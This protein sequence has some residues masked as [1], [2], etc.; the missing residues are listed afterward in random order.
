MSTLSPRTIAN[1]RNAKRSTGPKTARG[2]TRS[3]A[4]ALRH[5]LAASVRAD[6]HLD[7]Q[8]EALAKI[9]AGGEAGPARLDLARRVAEVQFDLMR[10]QRA[11]NATLDDPKLRSAS[12]SSDESRSV[13]GK[14]LQHNIRVAG[15]SLL[16]QA[17][18]GIISAGEKLG[19]AEGFEF[20]TEALRRLDRYERRALSR[21]RSLIRAY[22]KIL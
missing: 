9:I 4:N 3:A 11:R 22:A 15:L 20:L 16:E 7:T 12:P 1:R 18:L 10:I 8:I 6:P 21:R 17:K 5:S 2:K 14:L 13:R 19:L